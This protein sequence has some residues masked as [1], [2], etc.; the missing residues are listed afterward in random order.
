[1]DFV[2][3][4]PAINSNASDPMQ[5]NQQSFDHHS[6]NQPRPPTL[7]D[8]RRREL[9]NRAKRD[10]S[11]ASKLDGEAK[12]TPA[13]RARANT[14]HGASQAKGSGQGPSRDARKFRKI[15]DG[16]AIRPLPKRPDANRVKVVDPK[17]KKKVDAYLLTGY[18]CE[19]VI[20][21]ATKLSYHCSDGNVRVISGEKLYAALERTYAEMDEGEDA[22]K[23]GE[24]QQ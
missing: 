24:K 20:N 18:V 5:Q 14:A 11:P 22:K 19:R 16:F 8:P 13:K 10:L 1:M 3:S 7:A 21:G 23:G 9:L 12:S 17:G 4:T 15:P 6:G 2:D